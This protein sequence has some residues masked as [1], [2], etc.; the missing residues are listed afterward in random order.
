MSSQVAG[1][2]HAIHTEVPRRVQWPRTGPALFRLSQIAA[3]PRPTAAASDTVDPAEIRRFA[4]L[5]EEWW[6][7]AGKFRPLHA[8]NPVRLGFIRGQAL[9][10]FGRAPRQRAPLT[11]LDVLD[12]GCGG[13][14]L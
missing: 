8:L 4:A 9:A 3:M 11:G 5:A 6:A 12:T 7:P 14:V 2:V 1:Q 13:G 10:A